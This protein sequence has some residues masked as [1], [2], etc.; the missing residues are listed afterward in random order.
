MR[1]ALVADP[2]V[3]NHKR[4]GG[5]AV[6][7]INRRCRLTID[8]LSAAARI[9]ERRKAVLVVCG[10]LFDT[11]RPEPQVVAAVQEALR[12]VK[13]V[14]LRGNHDTVSEAPGDHALGPLEPVATV[15]EVPTFVMP[16]V[17]ALPFRPHPVKEWFDAALAEF[18]PMLGGV[19]VAH[20]GIEDADTPP[21]LRG[22]Q[23]SAHADHV[24]GV[25]RKHKFAALFVG[26]WHNHKHWGGS[27]DPL[28]VQVGTLCPTGWDNLGLVG[29]G[30]VVVYDTEDR[31]WEAVEV[32][33]PRF[34]KVR[35]RGA[36]ADLVDSP[37]VENAAP[38][39]VQFLS[40]PGEAVDDPEQVRSFLHR[41]L[42]AAG[43]LSND[44]IV[45]E[46]VPDEGDALVAARTAATAAKS[47]VTLEEAID[48]FA[49]A[50]ELPEG[51]VAEDV[52]AR[53]R[54]YLKGGGAA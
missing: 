42:Y 34:V 52:K 11:S 27:A 15:V 36:L 45:V 6:S 35:G 46:V 29:Y 31:S 17:V 28:V 37:G 26:N 33:G 39:F 10:D 4:H 40:P 47:A 16:G 2:H 9:A 49:G 43:K 23:D 21:W 51:V 14:V 25:L 53:A 8:A 19:A 54:R 5:E 24:L 7:G 18:A 44:G 48:G 12:S 13:T 20:F 3:G 41:K 1:L 50:M 32:P 38:L 22:A 30:K